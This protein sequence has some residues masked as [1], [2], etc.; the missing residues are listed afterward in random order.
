[1]GPGSV[2]LR[3]TGQTGAGAHVAVLT[4]NGFNL[5]TQV[6]RAD[7]VNDP[8]RD[9]DDDV[10]NGR[11]NGLARAIVR[12]AGCPDIVALEEIQDNDGAELSDVVSSER[13]LT[14]LISAVRRASGPSYEWA[15][16]PLEALPYAVQP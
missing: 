2:E 16:V 9:I 15:D 7:R 13:T 11:F 10:G 14:R 12:D 6:E 5:D 1:M 3:A 8:G 4:L